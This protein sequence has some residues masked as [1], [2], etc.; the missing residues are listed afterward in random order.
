VP[1]DTQDSLLRNKTNSTMATATA[2]ATTATTATTAGNNEP[3]FGTTRQEAGPA[4]W[5]CETNPMRRRRNAKRTQCDEGDPRNEATFGTTG[6]RRSPQD[7]GC[8][9]G[10]TAAN[11]NK[12]K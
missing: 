7:E 2:T 10:S 11:A 12:A 1:S 9:A 3:P 8:E 6:W 5:G 4:G